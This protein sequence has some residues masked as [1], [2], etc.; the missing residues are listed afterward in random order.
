MKHLLETLKSARWVEMLLLGALISVLLL[1]AMDGSGSV[2][3]SEEERMA[4]VLSEIEG[5]GSVEVMLGTD[6]RGCVVISE[7]AGDV[8]VMLSL[9]R[10]VRTLTG[11]PLDRIEIVKSG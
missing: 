3:L 11:L 6:G 4:K 1:L 9:Q 2:S 8:A 7:G 10:A 5:A